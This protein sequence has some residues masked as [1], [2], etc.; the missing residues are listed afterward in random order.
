MTPNSSRHFA[1]IVGASL[2]IVLAI[3]F[4]PVVEA[5]LQLALVGGI[6]VGGVVALVYALS[7]GYVERM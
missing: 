7:G 1:P 2:L 6:V 4:W 5:A 3:A